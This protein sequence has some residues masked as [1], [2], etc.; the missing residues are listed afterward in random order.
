MMMIIKPQSKIMTKINIAK[1]RFKWTKERVDTLIN[2]YK[3][4]YSIK[5]IAEELGTT[6]NSVSGKIKRLKQAG[7]L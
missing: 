5:T 7:E 1:G 3:E 4:S 6:G 2:L